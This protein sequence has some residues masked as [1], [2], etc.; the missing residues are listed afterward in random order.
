L[1]WPEG[2]MNWP[3][4]LEFGAMMLSSGELLALIAV[5]ES[6]RDG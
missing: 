2:L 4:G 5:I 3:K 6:Q 1:N